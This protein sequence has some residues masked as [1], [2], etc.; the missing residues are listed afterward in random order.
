MGDMGIAALSVGMHQ[1]QVQQGLNLAALKI[2]MESTVA[3]G[4]E[5]LEEMAVNLDPNLG[6]SVDISV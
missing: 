2:A 1:S 6:G 5:L 4:D 3:M